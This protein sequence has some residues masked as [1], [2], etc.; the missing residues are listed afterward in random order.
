MKYDNIPLYTDFDMDRGASLR[1][2][3]CANVE[4]SPN[5]RRDFTIPASGVNQI[6]PPEL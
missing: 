2:G 4:L 6:V 5:Q 1:A 3:V